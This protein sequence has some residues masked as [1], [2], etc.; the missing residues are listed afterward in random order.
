MLS[1]REDIDRRLT[2]AADEVRRRGIDVTAHLLGG[3][4]ADAVIDVAEQT[5]AAMIVIDPRHASAI[6][7]NT[8]FALD[9]QQGAQVTSAGNNVVIDN[10]AKETFSGTFALQ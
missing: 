9:I 4:T 3:D 1:N 7:Q 8:Q 2:A 5:D 10:A 6:T